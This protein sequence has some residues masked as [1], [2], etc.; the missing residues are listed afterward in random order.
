M[1]SLYTTSAGQ[2]SSVSCELVCVSVIHTGSWLFR[3]HRCATRHRD[4]HRCQH[5][6]LRYTIF[7]ALCSAT[8]PRRLRFPLS[9]LHQRRAAVFL[10]TAPLASS[11]PGKVR[12]C[13]PQ[14]SPFFLTRTITKLVYLYRHRKRCVRICMTC[15]HLLCILLVVC[16]KL[17]NLQ[18]RVIAF[19]SFNFPKIS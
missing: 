14:S 18:V 8:I 3:A 13:I 6:S 5:N 15:D 11:C 10:V 7:I 12:N 1:W 17:L 2:Q 16:F 4:Y 9:L 19:S